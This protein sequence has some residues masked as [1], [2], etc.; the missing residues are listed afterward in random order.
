[1]Q[2][3]I[4]KYGSE[5]TLR[6]L[7]TTRWGGTT[8]NA[9]GYDPDNIDFSQVPI[10][11]NKKVEPPVKSV[12]KCKYFAFN[13]KPGE[14]RHDDVVIH[15]RWC[16]AQEKRLA[17]VEP[18]DVLIVLGH[19]VDIK[20]QDENRIRTTEMFEPDTC[21]SDDGKQK[22]NV[23]GIVNDFGTDYDDLK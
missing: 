13:L 18:W 8:K 7:L 4:I 14:E 11:R 22:K 2:R 5:A 23:N 19:G 12:D 21:Q 6:E 1:V 9:F 17:K 20:E 16:N 10:T 3:Y 15:G